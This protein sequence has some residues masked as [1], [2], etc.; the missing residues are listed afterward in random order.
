[1]EVQGEG[2]RRREVKVDVYID[3]D[4]ASGCSPKSTSGGMLQWSRTQ[5]ARAWSSE[6]AEYYG[7][8]TG[9]VE[10]LGMQSLVEDLGWMAEVSLWTDH[11]AAK[12]IGNRR[13]P[14]RRAG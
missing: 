13:A 9:C 10:G 5:K 7:M 14:G 12:A 8:V 3:S 6:E 11:S 1:M 2:G 4:W